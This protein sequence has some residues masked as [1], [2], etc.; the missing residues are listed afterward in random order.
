[1]PKLNKMFRN[2]NCDYL[3]YILVVLFFLQC[4][5]CVNNRAFGLVWGELYICKLMTQS[6]LKW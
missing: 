5:T 2:G 1:M 3:K 6:S 4:K